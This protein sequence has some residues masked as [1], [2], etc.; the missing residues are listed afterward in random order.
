MPPPF[1]CASLPRGQGVEEAANPIESEGF[2]ERVERGRGG[3]ESSLLLGS[4]T[5]A[6]GLTGCG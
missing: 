6:W 3:E 4:L 1:V 5:T 2:Q